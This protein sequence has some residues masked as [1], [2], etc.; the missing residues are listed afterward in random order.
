MLP[1]NNM[2][3]LMQYAIID[4]VRSEAAPGLTGSC[5]CCGQPTVAKCGER[6][7]WHWAHKG[8]RTCDEWWEPETAW[9]RK[10]KNRFP[11]EWQEVIGHAPDGEKH[12]ADVR[13]AHGMVIEF[14]HS[15][16]KP[17][18]RRSRE[19]FYGNMVW[20]VDGRRLKRDYTR[21]LKGKSDFRKTPMEGVLVASF[22]EESFPGNWIDSGV[23]VAFDFYSSEEG[24]DF[25][26]KD[27][28]LWFLLPGR[29]G[30]S[31]LL[32]SLRRDMFVQ[33][34]MERGHILHAKE[35]VELIGNHYRQS[36]EQ[37]AR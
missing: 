36:R 24:E 12:I 35:I 23:L 27:V 29:A 16:L 18:E 14:Q 30:G 11:T 19:Q 9:H 37:A 3:T 4:G 5:H 28:P 13:T 21:F 33:L 31:A 22:V 25:P 6:R 32:G 8:K 7:V 15:H 26:E 10:W 20:V 34:A 17:E 2:E 1:L